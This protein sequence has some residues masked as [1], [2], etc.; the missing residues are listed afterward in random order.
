MAPMALICLPSLPWKAVEQGPRPGGKARD[1]TP[2][3]DTALLGGLLSFFL[4]GNQKDDGVD[5]PSS[6][7]KVKVLKCPPAS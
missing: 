3:T 2:L 5:M 7:V 1:A 6:R 4:E